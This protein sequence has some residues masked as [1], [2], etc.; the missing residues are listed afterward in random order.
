[1][2]TCFISFYAFVDADSRRF[3]E[4]YSIFDSIASL[5]LA[6]TILTLPV[7]KMEYVI[8]SLL[9]YRAGKASGINLI[10]LAESNKLLSKKCL[11]LILWPS[12]IVPVTVLTSYEVFS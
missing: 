2:R 1:M 10:S 12:L 8:L 5:D 7:L 3:L 6:P 11:K 4:R 9:R